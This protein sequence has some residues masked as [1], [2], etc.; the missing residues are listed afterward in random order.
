MKNT[1]PIKVN[2]KRNK[3][4][5]GCTD[6]IITVGDKTLDL[7]VFDDGFVLVHSH[8]SRVPIRFTSGL[9]YCAKIDKTHEDG[10]MYK[11]SFHEKPKN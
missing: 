1:N 3:R 11:V 7:T 9:E 6:V 10:T 5:M 2:H 4:V 8:A